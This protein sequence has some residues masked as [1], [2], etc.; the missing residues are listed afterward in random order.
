M[1]EGLRTE[2]VLLIDQGLLMGRKMLAMVSRRAGRNRNSRPRHGKSSHFI[3][4]IRS[5]N[6]SP[7]GHK[8]HLFR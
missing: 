5:L 8:R 7:S 2:S 6:L 4:L 3:R 1:M